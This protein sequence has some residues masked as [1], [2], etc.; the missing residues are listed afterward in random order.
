MICSEDCDGQ[1]KIIDLGR[2]W[3]TS[4]E[5]KCYVNCKLKC[6]ESQ[7]LYIRENTTLYDSFLQR[8]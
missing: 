4:N 6:C 5:L 2:S 1:E 3:Y 7:T 8:S